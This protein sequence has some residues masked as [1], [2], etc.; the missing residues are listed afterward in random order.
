MKPEKIL[1]AMNDIDAAFLTEA[2]QTA[3]ARRRSRKFAALIAAVI[4]LMTLT[5]TAFAAEEIAGWFKQYFGRQTEVPLTP[6]QIEFI[7]EN[8]QI[9]NNAQTCNGYTVQLKSAIGSGN[10]TYISFRVTAPTDISLSEWSTIGFTGDRVQDD[11]G[12]H[13]Q[14]VTYLVQDDGDGLDNTTNMILVLEQETPNPVSSWNIAIDAIYGQFYDR[15]YEQELLRT[16]YAHLPNLTTYTSEDWAK[17]LQRTVLVEG[18]WN[19]SVD[20]KHTDYGELRMLTKPIKTLMITTCPDPFNENITYPMTIG[21]FVLRPMDASLYYKCFDNCTQQHGFM[22]IFSEPFCHVVLKD[23]TKVAFRR[24]ISGS[25][26]EYRLVADSPIVLSEV[27]HV[28]LADGTK[29]MVP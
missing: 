13:P 16:K 24:S 6:G 17:I 14:V 15:E 3:P 4:A 8:E 9:I 5:V 25:E 27:D 10:T 23:G 22:T 2:R 19:F 7:E 28:L 18:S 21:S 29:L 20:V 12:N 26:N 1:Y 11:A